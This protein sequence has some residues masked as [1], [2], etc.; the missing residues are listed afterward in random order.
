MTIADIAKMAG[1]S[2]AAVSRYFNNGY[3]SKEKREA[4][5]KVVEETGYRPSVQAQTLRTKKTKMIG[6][7]LPRINSA[8]MSSVVEGVLSVL[9]ENDY[10]LLLANTQNNPKKE[11]EYLDFFSQKQVDGIIFVGTVFTPK[12]RKALDNLEIPVVIVGQHLDGYYCVYHDDYHA[13]YD[14]TKLF[15]DQGRNKIGFIGVFELDE[16]AG[17]ERRK[18][19]IYAAAMSGLEGIEDRYEIANFSIESGYEKAKSLMER[20]PDTDGIVCAT[21]AIAVGA[22]RYLKEIGKRIPEDVMLTGHGD[23]DMAYVTTPT[24]STVHFSYDKSGSIAANMIMDM[25]NKK[26]VDIKEVKLGYR[27]MNRESSME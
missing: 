19:F 7:I 17:L 3:I 23:S 25:V 18:G 27:I 8:A 16:A 6:V 24:L 9:D 1:V 22:M 13:A 21:D 5:Q 14:L 15:I 4:I 10:R 2:S 11:L 12:H 26:D 20:Y